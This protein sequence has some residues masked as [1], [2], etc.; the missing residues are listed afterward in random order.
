MTEASVKPQNKTENDSNIREGVV[1]SE[2]ALLPEKALLNQKA[3]AAVLG[4]DARTVRRMVDRY[5][6]P[7]A[8]PF[9]GR[10]M[11][12]A[13]QVL[14]FFEKTADRLMCEAEQRAEKFHED[15]SP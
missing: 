4:V 5:E 14:A 13:G 7:P 6:I 15:T 3:L 10:M 9:G 11:W 1:I 8:V 12:Q 2:L